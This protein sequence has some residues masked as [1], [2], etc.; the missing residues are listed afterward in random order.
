M[1]LLLDAGR[2][3]FLGVGRFDGDDRLQ[4]DGAGVGPDVHETHR[5]A[6]EANAV[7]KGLLLGV[8]SRKSRKRAGWM[9]MMAWGNASTITSVSIR[10][11][12]AR[13]TN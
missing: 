12:P 2:E 8:K 3:G 10:M 5:A 1:F 13:S 11:K 4:D 6:G 9:F 7:L